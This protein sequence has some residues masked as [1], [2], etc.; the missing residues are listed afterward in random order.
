MLSRLLF[1]LFLALPLSATPR[2]IDSNGSVL[3]SPFAGLR[4]PESPF[5][6]LAPNPLS[7]ISSLSPPSPRQCMPSAVR[8]RA[9]LLRPSDRPSLIAAAACSPGN[10]GCV[11]T[12]VE[13]FEYDCPV[14]GS[15]LECLPNLFDNAG[16]ECSLGEQQ[17]YIGCAASS[18][19]G[20]NCCVNYMTCSNH[21]TSCDD[22]SGGGGG[23]GR[24]PIWGDCG[25]AS[26]IMCPPDDN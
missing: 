21:N 3:S 17:N 13:T 24:A 18:G 10:A 14:P 22:E 12:Y 2:V 8:L 9:A 6:G 26:G 20:V 19:T 4:G 1:L 11:G 5:S 16:T 7:L 15:K 23:G 25:G